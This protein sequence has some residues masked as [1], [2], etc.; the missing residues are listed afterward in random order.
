MID[1]PV[2]DLNRKRSLINGTQT[3]MCGICHV[4]E[5]GAKP[6]VGLTCRHVYHAECIDGRI[7]KRST[8]RITVAHLNCPVCKNEFELNAAQAPNELLD[9]LNK[10]K[11][12]KARIRR[13]ALEIFNQDDL[14]QGATEAQKSDPFKF[15]IDQMTLYNCSSC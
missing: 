5:L 15:M 11:D 8:R 7:R 13:T 1:M 3:D 6:C 4:E 9:L 10:C 14:K 2:P 12:E